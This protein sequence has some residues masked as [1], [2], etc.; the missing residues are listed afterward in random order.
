MTIAVKTEMT[1]TTE[2]VVETDCNQVNHCRNLGDKALGVAGEHGGLPDVGQAKIQHDHALKANAAAT[3]GACAIF[4]GVD[5]VGDGCRVHTLG[6]RTN[7][8]HVGVVDAL[9][10]RANLL[11]AHV[12]IVRVCVRLVVVALHCVEGAAVH[13]PAV[14]RVEVSVVLLLHVDSQPLFHL[15]CEVIL[16]LQFEAHLSEHVDSLEMGELPVLSG[17][18]AHERSNRVLLRNQLDVGLVLAGKTMENIGQ[19]DVQHVQ[20]LKVMLEDLHL[21]VQAGKLAQMAMSVAGF[22]TEDGANLKNAAKIST[23]GHLLVKLRRLGQGSIL[24]EILELEHSRSALAGA[25]NEL[26]GVDLSESMSGQSLSPKA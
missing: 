23:D 14:D 15:G 24:V 5:V 3:V 4:E 6:G 21:H 7:L 25:S 9:C 19:N 11:A 18:I 1:G 2:D 26:G 16:V 22:G 8:Q 10:A 20:T 13:G 12:D 17:L